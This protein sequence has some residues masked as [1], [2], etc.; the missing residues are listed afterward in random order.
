M[1]TFFLFLFFVTV[2]SIMAFAIPLPGIV[3][4]GRDRNGRLNKECKR[5]HN[6]TMVGSISCEQCKE[7]I[8]ARK[9]SI[10]CREEL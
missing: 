10:E 9:N 4:I 5:L 2:G 1:K 3:K 7:F 8:K 6:G